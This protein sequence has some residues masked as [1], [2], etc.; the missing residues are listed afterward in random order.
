MKLKKACFLSF[1]SFTTFL[2]Q[3]SIAQS[4]LTPIGQFSN[5]EIQ[6]TKCSF[7]TEANAVI[8]MHEAYS[9]YDDY[10]HL[11]TEHHVR[12]KILNEKGIKEGDIVIP[13]W[14]KD[15]FEDV[16][17]TK[18]STF[19][20]DNGIASEI[21]VSK[22]DIFTRKNNERIGTVSFAFPAVKAGSIL[23]F[24]YQS[25]MKHYG[26][27]DKWEFQDRLPVV[28]SKYELLI[29]PNTEFTYVLH[30]TPEYKA[31]VKQNP[32]SGSIYFEMNNIPALDYEPYI[33]SRK[34]YLQQVEFQLSGLSTTSGAYGGST[35]TR[36]YMN[37]WE[38][39]S[40]ELL[41]TSE[42]GGMIG[43]KIPGTDEF[44]L[45]VKGLS[46]DQ[47]KMKAVYDFVAANMTW[48]HVY[49]RYAMDG[50]K[51]PWEKK[52]GTSAEINFILI[53]LLKEVGLDVSPALVSERWHGRVNPTYTFVDQFDNVVACV[54][55]GDQAYYLNA[56]E[57]YTPAIYTPYELLNTKALIVGKKTKELT[58]I[59]NE[60][61]QYNELI[62]NALTLTSDGTVNGS[63]DV[64][65]G[66]YAKVE[67]LG[68]FKD[69]EKSFIKNNFSDEEL[70]PVVTK[71]G[72]EGGDNDSS[73]FIQHCDFTAKLS[74]AGEFYFL[75]LNLFS[76][77]DKNPF[78]R[79]KRF[80][81]INFGYKR[82]IKLINLVT[83]PDNFVVEELPK[84]IRLTSEQKDIEMARAVEYNKE[85]KELKG[86]ITITFSKSLYEVNDYPVLQAF[87]KKMFELI[88]E[89]VLL[90][91]KE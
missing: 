14:R 66:G 80:S 2:V 89:P 1:L 62:I 79:D 23:D 36:K 41:S 55:I 29:V 81:N 90:K 53:S 18:A 30:K 83:L 31:I 13:F 47:Q 68:Q 34:D 28:S 7:D 75:P 61:L 59:K 10:Y 54:K 19:D 33:D 86:L 24:Q 21:P 91:K 46:T 65:S 9:N 76:G 17:I 70:L 50:L 64:Q 67:K 82:T 58:D 37:T 5:E 45:K 63:T 12:I 72:T 74:L 15:D 4:V 6:L 32:S 71:F 3:T 88:K 51:K 27:L 77:F 73:A 39:V 49:A 60:S 8:L 26:G 35:S 11:V 38:S 48:N 40:R 56:T 16:T 22:K 57:K 20:F 25:T 44:I 85:E 78:T 42:F 69:N 84:S 52:S 43:K 87:Y